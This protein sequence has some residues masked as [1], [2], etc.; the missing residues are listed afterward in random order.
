MPE[1]E[2]QFELKEEIRR[3]TVHRGVRFA[4]ETTVVAVA[5]RRSGRIDDDLRHRRV[6]VQI[7]DFA[8]IGQ[9]SDP[10]KHFFERR[11]R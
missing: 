9:F 3:F 6:L 7:I 2:K 8:L 4:A 10:E 1:E 5:A 11:V